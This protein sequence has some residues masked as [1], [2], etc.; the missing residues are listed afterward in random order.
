MSTVVSIRLKDEQIE[1]LRRAARQLGR[2]TSDA[3]SLLLE[4]ALRQ[5]E[6]AFIE[7]RDSPAGRQAYLKR[8]RVAVWWIEH[9]ARDLGENAEGIAALLEIPVSAVKSALA[10]AAAYPGEIA[11]AIA[12][13]E[14]PAE[15][16]DRAVPSLEI[17]T[18]NDAAAP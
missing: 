5:R 3:A 6:F 1:R 4:E 10:Y 11:E 7:F 15:E 9:L 2:R 12:D 14:R 8:S 16:L 17:F 18:V 13:N